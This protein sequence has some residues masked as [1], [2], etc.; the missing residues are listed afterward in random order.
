MPGLSPVPV[1]EPEGAGTKPCAGDR[2]QE[3]RQ[4][5]PYCLEEAHRVPGISPVPA[6]EPE[7]AGTKPSAGRRTTPALDIQ[8]E[9]LGLLPDHQATA[10]EANE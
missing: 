1:V 8:A 4:N 3:W 6:V 9:A 7:G 10:D 5:R 2:Q